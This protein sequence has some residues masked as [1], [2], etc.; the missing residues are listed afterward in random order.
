MTAGHDFERRLSADFHRELDAVIGPHPTW[1]DSPAAARIAASRG[2]SRWSVRL[3]AVAAVIAVAGGVAVVAGLRRDSTGGGCPTLADYAA[4]SAQPTPVDGTAPEV[5][6]PPVAPTA[7]MTTGILR[8]GDWAVIANADGPGLQLRVRDV[9]ECGR[10]PN[11][12]SSFAG[13]SLYLATVD[14]RVLRDDTGLAWL[15]VRTLFDGAVGST[16]GDARRVHGFDVPGVN[17]RTH[18]GTLGGFADSSLLIL[19]VPPTD[20]LVTVDHPTENTI[21][22]DGFDP[23]QPDWPRVR[24]VIRDGDPNGGLGTP[25]P[26]ATPGSTATTGEVVLGD[27]VTVIAPSGPGVLRLSG[28]DTVPAYPGLQPAP[29]H[30]FIE[31]LAEVI[32]FGRLDTRW[33]DWHAVGPDGRELVIVHDPEGTGPRPGMLLGLLNDVPARDGWIVVEAPA[34]GPVRLEYREY[35]SADAVFWLR[36]R[37]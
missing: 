27:P 35:G 21:G 36:L 17:D 20:K 4:A 2:G 25:V 14:A 28:L 19:D 32:D 10:L 5:T 24:W 34:R 11:L 37:D 31:V 15:G 16:P 7:T 23:T 22:L 13:G 8:P 29:G 12:R 9:R 30:V 6:F 3:L 26:P 33:R 1:A 18:V